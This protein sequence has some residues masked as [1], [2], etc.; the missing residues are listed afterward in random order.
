MI[1]RPRL[2]ALDID[3]TLP[4]WTE[5]EEE[6]A[7][8]A[9]SRILKVL[10]AALDSGAHVVLC[11]GRSPQGMTRVADRL[12]L[13]GQNGERMWI[14]ASNGAML[15][16]YAPLE[17]V[18]QETFDAGPA[19]RAFL[20][21]CP[22][23]L[24]AVEDQGIGY[25]LTAPFPAGELPGEMILAGLDDLLAQPASRVIVRDPAASSEH[26]A[27]LAAE[28]DLPGAG[29]AV[30]WSAWLDLTPA[31]VSKA[32]GLRHVCAELGVS[33]ADVLAVGDGRS[34]IEMLRFA[35]RGVAVAQAPQDVRD[36]ADAVTAAAE[37]DGVVLE[38]ERWFD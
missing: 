32:S 35:G 31:D 17:I 11:S 30:G 1:G 29:H 37:D 25:R 21:Q 5:G 28:L 7:E 16:R 22:S 9:G 23:A 26:F 4:A 8:P 13:Y 3:G 34:D 2:V 36:A 12:N 19:V 20:G 24:V 18:R 27:R 14:V 33:G 15:C 6:T 10:R 38:L